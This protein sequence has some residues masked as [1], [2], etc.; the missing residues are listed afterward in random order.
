MEKRGKI[1]ELDG[2]EFLKVRNQ[3]YAFPEH[4]HDTFCISLIEDGLEVIKMGDNLL[5]TE[6]GYISINNPCEI[7][8]NPI[9]E[10]S[11]NQ[12]FT[13]IYLSPDLV[14]TLLLRKATNFCHQQSGTSSQVELFRQII[15]TVKTKGKDN[16]ESK[17]LQLLS[18]FEIQ[19][20]SVQE[21]LKQSYREWTELTQ[22]IDNHLEEKITLDFLS[23]FMN[24]DKFNFAKE[25]RLKFGLSPINYVLMKKVFQS[26]ELITKE[27]NL[28]QLAYRF[29][30]SDQAHF[31]KQFK[32][33]IG[34]SPREYKNQL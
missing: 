15:E 31:S 28:S 9:V 16:L 19:S 27:T 6:Q 20:K 17:I 29:S 5:Y 2:I 32:R 22:L 34:V 4:Y 12:S 1:S 11:L 18:G 30:F 7:H 14:D 33:F 25:F 26:K 24:M 21:D 23:N 10:G 8:A 3:K 13:T